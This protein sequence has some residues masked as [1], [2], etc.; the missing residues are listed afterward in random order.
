MYEIK[1]VF[2]VNLFYVNLSIKPVKEPKRVEGKFSLPKFVKIFH[3]ES[4]VLISMRLTEIVFTMAYVVTSLLF[5]LFS[6]TNPLIVGKHMCHLCVYTL[7]CNT[8][9]YILSFAEKEAPLGS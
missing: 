7:F 2:S 4:P 5:F 9:K 8:W 3:G 1:F 6:P